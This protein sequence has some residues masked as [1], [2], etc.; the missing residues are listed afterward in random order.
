MEQQNS[1]YHSTEPI[2]T[3]EKAILSHHLHNN[4]TGYSTTTE[5]LYSHATHTRSNIPLNV[6]ANETDVWSNGVTPAVAKPA[7]GLGKHFIVIISFSF[8]SNDTKKLKFSYFF[9]SSIISC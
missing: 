4:S 7:R 1:L 5:S 6:A 9:R 3:K 2:Y 8:I